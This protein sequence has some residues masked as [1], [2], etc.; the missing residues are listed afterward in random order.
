VVTRS[1]SDAFYDRSNRIV[2]AH[3]DVFRPHGSH[4]LATA[5]Q[6][7]DYDSLIVRVEKL[8][9]N[10]KTLHGSLMSVYDCLKVLDA[11]RRRRMGL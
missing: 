4:P 10:A 9:E 2:S 7:K 5:P 1:L 11:P 8:Y 6:S 3:G